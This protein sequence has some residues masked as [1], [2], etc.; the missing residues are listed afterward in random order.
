MPLRELLP[1]QPGGV[2]IV[3]SIPSIRLSIPSSAGG[4]SNLNTGSQAPGTLLLQENWEKTKDEMDT[5]MTN[6]D[7]SF[8]S[9]FPGIDMEDVTEN[10][11]SNWGTFLY[12]Y[13]SNEEKKSKIHPDARESM[14]SRFEDCKLLDT[15]RD[16]NQIGISSSTMKEICKPM[17]PDNEGKYRKDRFTISFTDKSILVSEF[18]DEYGKEIPEILHPGVE[19]PEIDIKV[20]PDKQQEREKIQ[21]ELDEIISE[22]TRTLQDDP[23]ILSSCGISYVPPGWG[24]VKY[25]YGVKPRPV[26]IS[27]GSRVKPDKLPRVREIYNNYKML[28]E[29]STTS[30]ATTGPELSSATRDNLTGS[31]LFSEFMFDNF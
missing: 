19:Y 20:H 17:R 26:S 24:L 29:P 15:A 22:S 12:R 21:I 8:E 14:W 11:P 5:I 3:P 18:I 16:E 4:P 10:S 6:C 2:T 13:G 30:T 31:G 1:K 27:F 23:S 7:L 9:Q 28:K 25:A